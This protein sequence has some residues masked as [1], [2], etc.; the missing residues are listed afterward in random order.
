MARPM[1]PII[2][3]VDTQRREVPSSRGVPWQVY[4]SP[5]FV[6]VDV[7]SILSAAKYQPGNLKCIQFRLITNESPHFQRVSKYSLTKTRSKQISLTQF[8]FVQ[9]CLEIEWLLPHTL[10]SVLYKRVFLYYGKSC[11]R[12]QNS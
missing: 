12:P 2:A 9:L 3:E 8:F 5:P 7:S 6:Q 4:Q 1:N 11:T 10:I